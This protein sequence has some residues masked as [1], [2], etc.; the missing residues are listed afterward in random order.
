MRCPAC[1]FVSF[2]SRS[3]C[4]QCGK[5][6]PRQGKPGG[7]FAP[8]RP[9]SGLPSSAEEAA[10]RGL[11]LQ[12]AEEVAVA[13][14]P[15]VAVEVVPAGPMSLRTAG[16][17]LRSVAF[18]VDA[19]MVALLATGGA[20][21]VDLAVQIGGLISSAP[22]AGLEW[23]DTT[24]TSLL[25]VPIVLCYFTLFVGFR[26]QTPGKMLLGLKII[27]TTGQEVGYGRALVRW[28]GQCLGLLPLGLGFLMGAL[29]R[30]KQAL[31]DKIAGTYVV[32][33]PS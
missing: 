27:R 8:V 19:G 11:L 2:D 17:W 29:S 6:M 14:L 31:H 22:E 25:V 26:G 28:I 15:D 9:E 13:A 16:F 1:G 33:Y 18:L 12:D 30:K 23:L 3:P 4:K 20:M 24:A 10:A 5:E 7:I 21:L 32:R